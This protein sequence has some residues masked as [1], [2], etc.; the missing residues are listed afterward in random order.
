VGEFVYR[1]RPAPKG[2]EHVMIL[3]NHRI[4]IRDDGTGNVSA[5]VETL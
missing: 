3:Y 4:I 2:T 1:A 5:T